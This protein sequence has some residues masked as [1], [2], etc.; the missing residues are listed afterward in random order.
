MILNFEINFPLKVK[1]KETDTVSNDPFFKKKILLIIWVFP[2]N[3]YSNEFIHKQ[4]VLQ[5]FKER[6]LHA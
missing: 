6:R 1:Q 5:F 3:A 4:D 2:N